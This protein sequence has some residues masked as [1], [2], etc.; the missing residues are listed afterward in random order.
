MK[1]NAIIPLTVISFFIVV[2][3]LLISANKNNNQSQQPQ[4]TSDITV[5][6]NETSDKNITVEP[7]T[8]RISSVPSPTNTISVKPIETSIPSNSNTYTGKVTEYKSTVG[9]KN[10]RVLRLDSESL[11][12]YITTET[13]VMKNNETISRDDIKEGANVSISV[14][15]APGAYEATEVI[16]K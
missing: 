5:N 6:V 1:R 14:T 13:K 8:I 4:P 15:S 7:T 3:L 2:V 9:Y 10:S 16:I 11:N 12:F